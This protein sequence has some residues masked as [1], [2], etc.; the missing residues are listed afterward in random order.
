MLIAKPGINVSTK[1]VYENLR[2]DRHTVHPNIDALLD[3]IRAKD[4]HALSH[5]MGNI[6]ETVT[7]HQ[8][9]V[10]EEIKEHMKAHGAINAMMSGSGP[11]VF[12]LFEDEKGAQKAY[13]AMKKA[14]LAKQVYLTSIYNNRKS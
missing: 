4:L 13:E 12:G 3:A 14:R 8:Y 5:N 10:I 7:I 6:L 1:F 11:T 2:L 9:P